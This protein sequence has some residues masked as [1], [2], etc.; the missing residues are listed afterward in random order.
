MSLAL[1]PGSKAFQTGPGSS[2]SNTQ[3]NTFGPTASTLIINVY[4]DYPSMWSAL[5]T[6]SIDFLDGNILATDYNSIA[7]NPAF[8]TGDVELFGLREF[9]MNNIV[10]PFNVTEYRLGLASLADRVTWQ[11]AYFPSG[12]LPAYTVLQ[13]QGSWGDPLF[14]TSP[15]IPQNFLNAYLYFCEA[16]AHY[17]GYTGAPIMDPNNNAYSTWYFPN[18]YPTT[19][20]N[21]NPTPYDGSGPAVA[22]DQ[23]LF[24]I[25]TEAAERQASGDYLVACGSSHTAGVVSLPNFF[26]DPANTAAITAFFT[27]YP[28]YK[29]PGY[30]TGSPLYPQIDFFADHQGGSVTSVQVMTYY[31][32]QLYTGGWTTGSTPDFMEVWQSAYAPQNNGWGASAYNFASFMDTTFDNYV[33]EMLVANIT[34]AHTLADYAQEELIPT[35]CGVIPWYIYSGKTATLTSDYRAV[36]ALGVGFGNWWSFF[37]AMP[38]S[39]SPGYAQNTL[40]WGWE[41]DMHNTANPISAT[42]AWDWYMLGEIYDSLVSGNPYD[43]SSFYPGLADNY[44]V[45]VNPSVNGGNTVIAF[46]LRNDVWWQDVPYKDRTAYTVDHGAELN[47]PM[48][49]IPL[50]VLDV[51]YTYEMA[52]DFG[53][54]QPVHIATDAADV[55]HV[56][57]SSVWQSA[58]P[59]GTGNDPPWYNSTFAVSKGG[60]AFGNFVQF[61]PTLGSQT[62]KVYLTDQLTWLAYYTDMSIPIY[63]LHIFEYLACG[64]W[65]HN[66]VAVPTVYQMNLMP[67]AG[68]ANLLYGTGPFIWVSGTAGQS[69]TLIAYKQGAS[70]GG[71]QEQNSYFWYSPVRVSNADPLPVGEGDPDVVGISGGVLWQKLNLTNYD[72]SNAYQVQV[73]GHY[74][75]IWYNKTS[76]A[77]QRAF[78]Q[79]GALSTLPVTVTVPAGAI[80]YTVYLSSAT[81]APGS[82]PLVK[83]PYDS[84]ICVWTA[85]TAEILNSSKYTGLTLRGGSYDNN[86]NAMWDTADMVNH[87]NGD[88]YAVIDVHPGDVFGATQPY[89]WPYIAA[90]GECYTQD[91]TIITFNWHQHISDALNYAIDGPNSNSNAQKLRADINGDGYIDQSDITL[92]TF[93]WYSTIHYLWPK[94]GF[95]APNPPS[96]TYLNP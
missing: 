16:E 91:V 48:Q 27:E 42:W 29:Y 6:Q 82:P 7:S 74:D 86:G 75:F 11:N 19:G 71:I 50:T 36:N 2:P 14:N 13:S 90:D 63:P 70:Y 79:N 77:W 94:S 34:Y 33:N 62:I 76:G 84:Y 95:V 96:P 39:G 87:P 80:T 54:F 78:G 22:Q 20:S 18:P 5:S 10:A 58:W 4:T 67:L 61:D 47:G 25:R 85:Y 51:A 26:A 49:N 55:D 52:R 53:S 43:T 69:Y 57:V 64:A 88:T 68:G 45:T 92:I 73:T 17:A 9:D 24:Y 30:G 12:G 56:V 31:R 41:N 72:T 46:H 93:N 81:N 37:D 35:M 65:M 38:T 83:M 66:G 32:F 40:T 59:W 1:I 89:K 3:Y 60:N 21:P 23:I 8:T 28:Q 44:S 15:A